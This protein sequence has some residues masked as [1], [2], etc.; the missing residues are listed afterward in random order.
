MTK[1]L[2]YT[3]QGSYFSAVITDDRHVF[4]TLAALRTP[5]VSVVVFVPISIRISIERHE[6]STLVVQFLHVQ[7]AVLCVASAVHPVKAVLTYDLGSALD[8]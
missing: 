8:V 5:A 4:H 1:L 6:T 7:L 2:K 3:R